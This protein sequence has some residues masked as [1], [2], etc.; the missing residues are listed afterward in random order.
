MQLFRKLSTFYGSWTFIT[1]L[2]WV[3]HRCLS[4][5]ESHIHILI[6]YFF[7][8]RFNIILP[9]TPTFYVV[10]FLPGFLMKI[11]YTF[12]ISSTYVTCLDL[13]PFILSFQQYLANRLNYEAPFYAVICSLLLL[14][15]LRFKWGSLVQVLNVHHWIAAWQIFNASSNHNMVP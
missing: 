10:P 6:S 9:P 5:G 15:P 11:L 1:V 13:S 14:S 2:R 4:L 8:H 12:L 7:K 3:H